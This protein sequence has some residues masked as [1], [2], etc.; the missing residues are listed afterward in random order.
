M[1]EQK[2]TPQQAWEE[3]KQKLLKHAPKREA[4]QS[5]QEYQ[6]ASMSYRRRFGALLRPLP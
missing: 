3:R 5:D 6:E 4:Y 1:E 2:R